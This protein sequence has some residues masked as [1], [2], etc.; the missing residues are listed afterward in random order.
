MDLI[1]TL[2]A[3]D[4]RG[5]G[6][7]SAGKPASR[8]TTHTADRAVVTGETTW[9]GEGHHLLQQ[10]ANPVASLH[11]ATYGKAVVTHAKASVSSDRADLRDVLNPS[12]DKGCCELK[13]PIARG[14]W[15]QSRREEMLCGA[16]G[17][18]LASSR[19]NSSSNSVYLSC[20]S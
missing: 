3:V 2:F 10:S 14:S 17:I 5:S 15:G 16:L 1:N 20:C 18:E 8:V 9:N 19:G 13:V 6:T 11:G 7:A 4:A 12:D